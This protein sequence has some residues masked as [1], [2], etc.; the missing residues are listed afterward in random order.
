MSYKSLD[1]VCGMDEITK[2]EVENCDKLVLK[3]V[4]DG[5]EKTLISIVPKDK[6]ALAFKTVALI[7]STDYDFA[8]KEKG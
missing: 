8:V 5:K 4:K 7:A 6:K 2:L 1:E 3:A